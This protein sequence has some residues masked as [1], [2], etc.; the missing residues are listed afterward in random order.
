MTPSKRSS[1]RQTDVRRVVRAAHAEGLTT[2]AIKVEPNGDF[3]IDVGDL[4]EQVTSPLD[5]WRGRHGSLAQ[6]H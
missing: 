5:E 2:R 3:T 4:V 1:V 6:R